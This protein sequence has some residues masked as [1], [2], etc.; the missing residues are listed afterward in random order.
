MYCETTQKSSALRVG[1]RLVFT[2]TKQGA[3]TVCAYRD[4]AIMRLDD[5]EKRQDSWKLNYAEWLKFSNMLANALNVNIVF[6]KSKQT[7]SGDTIIAY[8]LVGRSDTE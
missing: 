8:D 2:K 4:G 7:R 5:R 3:C 6:F 1:D